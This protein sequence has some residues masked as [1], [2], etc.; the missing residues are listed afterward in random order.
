MIEI[1]ETAQ[2]RYTQLNDL[3]SGVTLYPRNHKPA[4]CV[5]DFYPMASAEW[6]CGYFSLEA[7]GNT[8][9]ET[10]CLSHWQQQGY[11]QIRLSMTRD[12]DNRYQL[13]VLTVLDG[14]DALLMD[15]VVWMEYIYIKKCDQ[16]FPSFCVEHLTLQQP[17]KACTNLQMPGQIWESSHLLRK[18]FHVI[19]HW[20]VLTGSEIITEIPEYFHTAYIFSQYFHYIDDEMESIFQSFVKKEL[21]PNP[22]RREV[23]ELSQKFEAGLIY[24]NGQKYLWPTEMQIY[25]LSSGRGVS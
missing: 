12:E 17:G 5:G 18:M 3:L 10:G 15:L 24:R 20:A 23:T 2:T 8:F 13:S 19:S 7:I 21:P 16:S 25:V 22:S 1:M 4:R 9:A 14:E 6:F 11:R